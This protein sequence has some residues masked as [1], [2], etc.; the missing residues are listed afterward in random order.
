MAEVNLSQAE[1]IQLRRI[2]DSD[3]EEALLLEFAHRI[4]K[5]LLLQI[6]ALMN[7]NPEA[8]KQGVQ[9]ALVAKTADLPDDIFMTTAEVGELFRVSQQQV[10][11][12]C[13]EG[14]VSAERTPGGSWRIPRSQFDGVGFL[15]RTKQAGKAGIREVAGGWNG[16]K[17]L[18]D[19]LRFGREDED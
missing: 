2:A 1:L 15:N 10:R 18:M 11:R 12:W 4:V 7:E 16:R 19:A 9:I 14:R 8:A 17:E 13:E 5:P 6:R 3:Q